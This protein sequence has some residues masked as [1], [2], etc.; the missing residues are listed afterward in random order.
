MLTVDPAQQNPRDASEK[1]W[2]L[3]L[4]RRTS[5]RAKPISLSNEVSFTILQPGYSTVWCLWRFVAE[6]AEPESDMLTNAEAPSR[7]VLGVA[8]TSIHRG[9]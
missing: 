5:A 3:V 4:S 9:L 2:R 8:A 7:A 6:V 1:D